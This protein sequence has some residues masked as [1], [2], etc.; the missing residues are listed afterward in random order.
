M[1]TMWTMV[2]QRLLGGM[3]FNLHTGFLFDYLRKLDYPYKHVAQYV[4]NSVVMGG[5]DT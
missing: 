4:L 2:L 1:V 5:H 3:L